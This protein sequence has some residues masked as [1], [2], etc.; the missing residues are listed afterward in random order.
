MI[1]NFPQWWALLTYECFKSHVNFTEGLIFFH[2][3]GSRLG[4]RRLG[5]TFSINRMIIPGEEGKAQT[6]Q[7]L[8]MVLQKVY[9]QISQRQII[10]IVSTS[11]QKFSSRVRTESFLLSTFIL[12]TI[13][14]FLTGSRRLIHVLRRERHQILGP[15]WVLL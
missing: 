3:R 14:L 6:R 1:Y 5:Q 10:M 13:C 4:R 7:L 2:R 11:I 9:D 8:E 15:A 12:I